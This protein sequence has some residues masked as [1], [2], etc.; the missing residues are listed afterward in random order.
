MSHTPEEEHLL[1][2]MAEL[3]SRR[4]YITGEVDFPRPLP[5]ADA[6]AIAEDVQAAV[7]QG[8]AVRAE[9]IAQ[10]GDVIA[11]HAGCS[12]CCEQLVMIYAGEAELIAEWLR[13]PEQADIKRAFLDAYPQWWERLGDSIDNIIALT[14]ARDSARQFAALVAHWRRRVLCAFN[15]DGLCTIYPVRPV[16]CRSYHALDTSE[17]C[18]PSDDTGSAATHMY[19]KP[20]EEFLDK[21]RSL[22]MAVHHAL[23]GPK[24]RP[25]PLCKAVHDRLVRD[26]AA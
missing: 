3:T 4:E 23:G 22:S 21:T 12:A 11:C 1:V 25:E 2:L 26:G 14:D 19:F 13:A 8:T 16:L 15:R 9:I 18:R 7:D 10:K 6:V 17:N 24:G 5:R 20:L